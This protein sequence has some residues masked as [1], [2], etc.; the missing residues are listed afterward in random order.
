[1]LST[2]ENGKI[3]RGLEGIPSKGLVLLI[4]NHMLLG[5]ETIPLILHFMDEKKIFERD[6]TSN[7]V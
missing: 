6:S 2:L 5:I 4:G 7:D 3:V 1:M